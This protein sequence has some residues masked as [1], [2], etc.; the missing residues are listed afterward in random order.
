MLSLS[1][2]QQPV[3]RQSITNPEMRPVASPAAFKS[4]PKRKRASKDGATMSANPVSTSSPA[5]ARVNSVA[6]VV[7]LAFK[8]GLHQ[9][10]ILHEPAMQ[11]AAG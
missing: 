6:E 10:P 11:V 2:G 1:R 8:K 9:S 3:A 5:A 4:E 7:R